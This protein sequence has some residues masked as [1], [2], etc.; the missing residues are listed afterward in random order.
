MMHYG[1]PTSGSSYSKF[2]RFYSLSLCAIGL[3]TLGAFLFLDHELNAFLNSL[4]NYTG[5]SGSTTA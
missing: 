3:E 4:L 5:I 2:L 1:L